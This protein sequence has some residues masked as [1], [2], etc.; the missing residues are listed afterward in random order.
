MDQLGETS[1]PFEEEKTKRSALNVSFVDENQLENTS[2]DESRRRD[3]SPTVIRRH[4]EGNIDTEGGRSANFTLTKSISERILQLGV[5]SSQK[6]VDMSSPN[7]CIRSDLDS[8]SKTAIVDSHTSYRQDIDEEI[9]QL[10]FQLVRFQALA[11]SLEHQLKQRDSENDCLG[12]QLLLVTDQRNDTSKRLTE[13]E[14]VISHLQDNVRESALERVELQAKLHSLTEENLKLRHATK[15]YKGECRRLK[16]DLE[17]ANDD[18]EGKSMTIQ[19]LKSEND[20]LKNQ[21]WTGKENG[22]VDS[23]DNEK[24]VAITGMK[25]LLSTSSGRSRRRKKSTR[26][27]ELDDAIIP[28]KREEIDQITIDA[29]DLVT[30]PQTD[31]EDRTAGY[32][33]LTDFQLRSATESGVDRKKNRKNGDKNEFISK[34]A[35]RHGV[36]QTDDS[37]TQGTNLVPR[38]NKSFKSQ[39]SSSF[40]TLSLAASDKKPSFRSTLSS[41]SLRETEEEQDPK[42]PTNNTNTWSIW[43]IFGTGGTSKTGGTG[44]TSKVGDQGEDKTKEL[45]DASHSSEEFIQN[46]KQ[47]D[48]STPAKFKEPKAGV[49]M[50]KRFGT[51]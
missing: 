20:W 26:C 50:P 4:S 17:Y 33:S 15:R 22:D 7:Y 16:K 14:T 38:R 23:D 40:K 3:T 8:T 27:K 24:G 28:D 36:S 5:S 21:L 43:G 18:L 46:Q 2:V 25:E 6:Q 19:G 37:S 41:M 51:A 9:T 13:L 30:L 10:K 47:N 11:D 48:V 34:L 31:G 39:H 44:G 32:T 45:S 1:V 29:E 49:L 35:E 42:D 12:Q